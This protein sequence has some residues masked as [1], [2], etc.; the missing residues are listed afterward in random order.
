MSICFD[1]IRSCIDI[2][3]GSSSRGCGVDLSVEAER[4]GHGG[5]RQQHCE[6]LSLLSFEVKVEADGI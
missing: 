6:D 4:I 3:S 2:Q 1:I 5:Y